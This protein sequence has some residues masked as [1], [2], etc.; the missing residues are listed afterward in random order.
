MSVVPIGQIVAGLGLTAATILLIKFKTSESKNNEIDQEDDYDQ[1]I[2]S[3]SHLDDHLIGLEK[4]FSV[5]ALRSNRQISSGTLK[6]YTF[7]VGL[8]NVA[9]TC[10][11]NS[12]LQALSG[13]TKFTD[14][15]NRVWSNIE[16]DENS[17]DEIAVYFFVRSIRE[18]RDGSHEAQEWAEHLHDM[19]CNAD[20]SGSSGVPFT[21]LFEQQD[22]H[23]LMFYL[24]EKVTKITAKFARHRARQE[25]LSVS[26]D[27]L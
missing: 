1:P 18:L 19:L 23:D 22:S 4:I 27:L 15:F 13:C 3:L 6:K 17:D 8:P 14:Y 20:T 2:N 10:Y 7:A 9:N 21:R 25:G 24:L 12:L 26:I 16:V 5:E 11:M